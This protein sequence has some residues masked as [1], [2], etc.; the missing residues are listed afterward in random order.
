M[1][2]T[3]GR[4][5]I[6]SHKEEN[7]RHEGEYLYYPMLLDYEKEETGKRLLKKGTR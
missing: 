6:L 7:R 4:V 2:D 3:W 5:V 1:L